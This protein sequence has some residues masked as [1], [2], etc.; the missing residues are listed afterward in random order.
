MELDI[1]KNKTTWNDASGSINL[2]FQ[3]LKHAIAT[4]I[5]E[6]S[7]LDEQ[8][9][10]DYLM[11]NGYTT[12]DWV[13]AKN[14]LNEI[15]LEKYGSD[16]I[17][18]V[19]SKIEL[20]IDTQGGL[21]KTEQGLGIV[22]IPSGLLDGYAKVEDISKEY[23]TILALELLDER[24]AEIED[25]FSS[26]ADK[27]DIPTKVS[28]LEN[29][30]E[31]ITS[32]AIENKVDKE[33]GKGLSSNDYTDKEKSKLANIEEGAQVNVQSDWN[34]NDG[35]AFIKNKPTIPSEVT[36]STVI[37]W[38][39]TKNTGTYSKPL[40][41]I[42]ESDLAGDVQNILE[43]AANSLQTIVPGSNYIGV[44]AK[45]N[46][47]ITITPKVVK[48][49]VATAIENG[50][51]SANDVKTYV[52]TQLEGIVRQE[53]SITPTASPN[54]LGYAG[55]G[56]GWPV[57]GP[58]MVWGSGS[59]VARLCVNIWETNPT[60][61]ISCLAGDA[62][63]EWATF[64]TS[65]NVGQYAMKVESGILSGANLN[66]LMTPG[67]YNTWASTSNNPSSNEATILVVSSKNNY[68]TSQILTNSQGHLYSRM[69]EG[70]TWGDWRTV[71]DT[72][73]IGTTSLSSLNLNND[74]IT[75][76]SDLKS[77]IAY[78][79][80]E[81][82]FK[83][84]TL[85]GYGITD[86]AMYSA[87]I[88]TTSNAAYKHIGYAYSSGGWSVNGPALSFGLN[89]SNYVKLLFPDANDWYQGRIFYR[90]IHSGVDTGMWYEIITAQSLGSYGMA[91]IT[92]DSN[93]DGTRD[94]TPTDTRNFFSYAYGDLGWKT[95][96]PAMTF[97][98]PN[99]KGLF[100]IAMY[101]PATNDNGVAAYIAVRYYNNISKWSLIITE[102]NLE[103]RA[104]LSSLMQSNIN[105]DDLT[106]IGSYGLAGNISNSLTNYG[107]LLTFGPK[108]YSFRGQIVIDTYNE[109]YFR[110]KSDS[111]LND[112]YWR[113]W[114][115]ILDDTNYN[116][117]ALSKSG[118][119]VSGQIFIKTASGDRFFRSQSDAYD[120]A[121]GIGAGG[122]NRGIF[123]STNSEWW[124]MRDGN[125]H[126]IIAGTVNVYG[127]LSS[128]AG[129]KI[130]GQTIA[131]WADVAN[132]ISFSGIDKDTFLMP[133]NSFDHSGRLEHSYAA[134]A[135]YAADKRFSVSGSGFSYFN[136]S[137]LFDGSYE[138]GYCARVETGAT[139]TMTISNNGSNII[140]GYP[141]GDIYLSFYY[142]NVPA[143]VKVEVYCNYASQG[144]GWKT[145]TLKGRRGDHNDVWYYN[146]SYYDVTQLRITITASASIAAAL[147]EIDWHLSRAALSN[148]PIVTKFGIDQTLYGHMKFAN[149]VTM[150]SNV[151]MESNVTTQSKVKM[152]STNGHTVE[153]DG[154]ALKVNSGLYIGSGYSLRLNGQAI[155]NWSDLGTYI[156]PISSETTSEK[157]ISPNTFYK[158]GS[159]SAL[160]ITLGAATN[161][162][163]INNY[164]FEFT[165]S[166]GFILGGLSGV[167][168][169]DGVKPNIKAGYTY[170]FSIINNCATYSAFKTA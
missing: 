14:Y 111:L 56:E 163:H 31:Y 75:S 89:G 12:K 49:D 82:N 97:G 41:G 32:A 1:I 42:P 148:L 146:N 139:A 154:Y 98:A 25:Y 65:L 39:F 48:V 68:M 142:N 94:L 138:S 76:W 86:G 128:D 117:Y 104:M 131:K 167:K 45:T 6:G 103:D 11:A 58:V 107:S 34:A 87:S 71:L 109:M 113:P 137:Q 160:S 70:G 78:S 72:D 155:T 81:I 15:A 118:G 61:L 4:L 55:G 156:T 37:E 147:T 152:E 161:N 79:F 85:S 26:K 149:N 13:L 125:K 99:Y 33:E 38:G 130:G 166:T 47:T 159:V 23:A 27:K 74:T 140:A 100:N 28:Q 54:V 80:S 162:T 17:S 129:L 59:Y 108:N 92:A 153:F 53:N 114:R 141:Y 9:L 36:E 7:G 164:M 105:I 40:G 150:Q 84:T 110:A 50:L 168:W 60:M 165:A 121:F 83:P 151:T 8:Q 93:G 102:H 51:A 3:K 20:I 95:V 88:D 145:L 30:K 16:F 90:H 144:I 10:A 67:A 119:T 133:T 52:N 96:G 19:N 63:T 18:V 126:T 43:M 123:D 122:T 2:N 64:V 101:N 115:K 73:N 112:S 127:L 46:N 77:K 124:I 132:Y 24:L 135:L 170:Q 120:L 29:D 169:A 44:S 91:Y 157:T 57:G 158:W 22:D 106:S 116:S 66:E 134:N 136:A 69:N 21:G 35:D 62:A 5:A 143:D